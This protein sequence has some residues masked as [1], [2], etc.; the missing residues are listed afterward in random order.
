MLQGLPVGTPTKEFARVGLPIAGD[1]LMGAMGPSGKGLSVG[2]KAVN[3]AIR[4]LM[5]GAGAGA[6]SV[7][8]QQISEGK[9]DPAE[10]AREATI[11]LAGEPALSG[12]GGF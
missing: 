6:G 4:A 8:G 2:G 7:A 9:I 10:V 1:V 3:L 11:G 12:L 5:S